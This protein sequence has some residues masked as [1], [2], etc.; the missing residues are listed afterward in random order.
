MTYR[1]ANAKP[2]TVKRRAEKAIYFKNRYIADENFR[3]KKKAY[4]RAY[5]KQVLETRPDTI[6]YYKAKCYFRKL[7][8]AWRRK[9][10]KEVLGREAIEK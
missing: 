3:E 9:F 8:P 5:N 7:S 6:N 2:I 4:N 1:K 10:R